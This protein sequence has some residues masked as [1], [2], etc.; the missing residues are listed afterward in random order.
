MVY[1]TL[2]PIRYY[3]LHTPICHTYYTLFDIMPAKKY[4]FELLQKFCS[5]NNIEL[6]Q[7]YSNTKL[8]REVK[9][10]TRCL[11]ENCPNISH[12]NVIRLMYKSGSYCDACAHNRGKEKQKKTCLEKYGT[13]FPLQADSVKKKSRD[14]CLEKWCNSKLL[15]IMQKIFNIYNWLVI[16]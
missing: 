14:T 6:L 10:E 2:F 1:T 13:E 7:D 4:T 5:E 16:I 8:V 9:L 11:T 3:Y 12:K 15:D